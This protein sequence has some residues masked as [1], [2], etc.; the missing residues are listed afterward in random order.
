GSVTVMEGYVG[1]SVS[2]RPATAEV[3][4]EVAAERPGRRRWVL[5]AASLA[6]GLAFLDATIVNIAFPNVQAS[7]PEVSRSW[8]SWILNGYNIVFAALLVPAGRIAD[9]LGRRRVFAAGVVTFAVASL[10]C[11]LAPSAGVLVG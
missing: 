8:L 5:L 2:S 4:A 11:A 1:E 3:A 7:F 10:V 9:L 6:A